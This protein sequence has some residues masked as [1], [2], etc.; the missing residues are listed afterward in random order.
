MP[1]VKNGLNE[2]ERCVPKIMTVVME[3]SSEPCGRCTL[4]QWAERRKKTCLTFSFLAHKVQVVTRRATGTSNVLPPRA[5]QGV[6]F[7][8]A[9]DNMYSFHL[10]QSCGQGCSS[11]QYS[12]SFRSQQQVGSQFLTKLC[13]DSTFRCQR[14]VCCSASEGVL[15]AESIWLPLTLVTLSE[16]LVHP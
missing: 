14:C 8:Y 13:R 1:L 7:N 5:L 11:Q 6:C 3:V 9:N 16:W 2:A 15:T 10:A 4:Y 12:V